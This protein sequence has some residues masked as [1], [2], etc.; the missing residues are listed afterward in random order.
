MEDRG[1]EHLSPVEE[2]TSSTSTSSS[3]EPDSTVLDL[4]VSLGDSRAYQLVYLLFQLLFIP[5]LTIEEHEDVTAVHRVTLPRTLDELQQDD[6]YLR[7]L[8][9]LSVWYDGVGTATKKPMEMTDYDSVRVEILQS[10]LLTLCDSIY[11]PPSLEMGLYNS[12]WMCVVTAEDFPFA[13]LAFHSLLNGVLGKPLPGMSV[14]EGCVWMAGYQEPWSHVPFKEYLMTD[15][16]L[17]VME[18]SLRL[19]LVLLDYGVPYVRYA[20]KKQDERIDSSTAAMEATEEAVEEDEGAF[21]RCL[22]PVC[23]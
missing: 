10:L 20:S 2:G 17:S 18:N 4:D 12:P 14:G 13:S 3:H 7:R 19:L 23:V 6:T 11:A 15:T 22:P 8:N 9:S 16:S 5:A 1:L 21:S